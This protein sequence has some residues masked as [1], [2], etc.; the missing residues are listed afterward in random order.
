[1]APLDSL[2]LLKSYLGSQQYDTVVG[3][4]IEPQPFVTV[5][6]ESGAGG[7]TVGHR[8]RER[9]CA[10]DKRA[11]SPWLWFDRELIQKAADDHHL[12]QEIASLMD[13]SQY[14]RLLRWVDELTGRY[15]SWSTV[16][17]KTNET[18]IQLARMGNV[19]LAGRGAN[20]VTRSLAG[21]VHVRL[22]GSLPQRVAHVAEYYHLSRAEAEKFVTREDHARAMYV[23]DYFSEDIADPHAYDVTINTDH[24]GFED[25]VSIMIE[26]VAR[27]RIALMEKAAEKRG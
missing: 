10:E 3:R 27:V 15:P 25:A 24:V 4:G 21:G 8:L 5:S 1:M 12:P 26:R 6:R 20:V 22:V 14:D 23:K 17:R 19:I 7:V 11:R 16:V 2:N 13:Q 18:I 9:L